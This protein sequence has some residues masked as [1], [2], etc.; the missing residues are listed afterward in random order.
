M[1]LSELNP[2]DIE[3]VS[4]APALAPSSS[5]GGLKLSQLSPEDIQPANDMT[6]AEALVRGGVQGATAGFSDEIYGGLG[7]I[8]S[9]VQVLGSDDKMGKLKQLYQQYRDLERQKNEIADKEHQKSYL[10]GNVIG[11]VA[12]LGKVGAGIKGAM[13]LGAASGLGTSNADLT[14][15]EFGRAA[16]DTGIGATVGGIAG[17]LGQVAGNALSP[18]ALNKTAALNVADALRIKDVESVRQ[19]VGA[20]AIKGG[21]LKDGVKES[22][23]AGIRTASD[24]VEAELQ[25]AL[26]N[27]AL[28][29][30]NKS[31]EEVLEKMGGDAGDKVLELIRSNLDSMKDMTEDMTHD[32]GEH[33]APK[34]QEFVL[35]LKEAGNDPVRL[36]EIKRAA[37]E[38]AKK[39]Y[40][41]L[42]KS[43][44]P[45]SA[46]LPA[47][48][49]AWAKMADKI[50][51]TIKGHIEGL[52]GI[53]DE[54]IEGSP[55]LTTIKQANYDLGGMSQAGGALKAV[56]KKGPEAIKSG[57]PGGYY[58][59]PIISGVT[60]VARNFATPFRTAKA[61]GRTKMAGFLDKYGI[62]ES[63]SPVAQKGTEGYLRSN[64][65][66]E[67]AQ[68]ITGGSK[69]NM[70]K[71]AEI[72]RSLYDQSDDQLQSIADTLGNTPGS[73]HI[74]ANLSNAIAN[75]DVQAKN[76]A[77]FV[78]SSNPRMRKL[79]KER[80]L[81]NTE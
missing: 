30:K 3:L 28:G 56:L 69:P 54:G 12:G 22:S 81:L 18:K 2:K 46:P 58:S 73:E 4:E 53:V 26:Q 70:E 13:A 24:A 1:K 27:V 64:P 19:K 5:G 74:A 63:L 77:L 59:H 55:L 60:D 15:G 75:K 71:P 11:G 40:V 45:G 78:L 47:E 33:I 52:A 50:G 37:Y 32:F 7:A 14:E 35:K 43:R 65:M 68:E 10:A 23:L 38:Q 25:P 67:E 8:A 49:E 17:K 48:Y 62:G 61:V 21:F 16:I 57:H 42:K 36:N 29:L 41:M 80:G 76:S 66:I 6:D 20:A 44:V 9:P 34:M 51:T 72:S 79:L 39:H 31:Q